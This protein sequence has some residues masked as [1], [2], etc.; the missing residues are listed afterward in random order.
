VPE[1]R[2]SGRWLRAAGL[3]LGRHFEIEVQAGRL[4]VRTV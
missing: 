4:T 3:D 1:L 2:L